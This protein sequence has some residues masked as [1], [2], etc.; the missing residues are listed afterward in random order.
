VANTLNLFRGG[1]VGFIVWSD[2][3]RV[4]L[5]LNDDP[6]KDAE[7]NEKR[8]L[9]EG[10]LLKSVGKWLNNEQCKPNRREPADCDTPRDSC[11]P[12]ATPQSDGETDKREAERDIRDRRAE[13]VTTPMVWLQ[14]HHGSTTAKNFP[15]CDS[16]VY[17]EC[18]DSE[19]KTTKN[20]SDRSEE[21][22]AI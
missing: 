21:A 2:R 17:A 10:N 18:A 4:T 15:V 5:P 9:T 12:R 19:E 13:P 20:G 11:A 3:F 16:S 22:H 14:S 7:S 8:N 1:A 6:T